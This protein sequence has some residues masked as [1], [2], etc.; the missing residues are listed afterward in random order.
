MIPLAQNPPTKL[1]KFFFILN[2]T[3]PLVIT[4]FEQLSCW[5]CCRVMAGQ[6]LPWKDKLCSFWKVLK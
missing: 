1:R 3:T 2:Y 5:I 4:G 6:N